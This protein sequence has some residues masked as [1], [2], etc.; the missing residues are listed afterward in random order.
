MRTG[1]LR[2]LFCRSFLRG[3]L[4]RLDLFGQR[5]GQSSCLEGLP[6]GERRKGLSLASISDRVSLR[7]LDPTTSAIGGLGS[8][9]SDSGVLAWILAD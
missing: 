7:G 8:G 6:G 3:G 1:G 5:T 4:E 9:F 2:D